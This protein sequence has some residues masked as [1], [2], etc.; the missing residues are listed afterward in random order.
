MISILSWNIQQGGGSRITAIGKALDEMAAHIVVLSEFR[1]NATGSKLRQRCMQMGYRHQF[2]SQA[3]ANANSV[4]VLSKLPANSTLFPK[5]DPVY[6]HNVIRAEFDAFS[7]YGLYMPH[8]KEHKL[9]DFLSSRLEQD[10]LPAI[11][12]GDFNSGINYVDQ[13]GNSFWYE[14]D[15]KSLLKNGFADAFRLKQGEVSEFSWYSHQGN[16]FR[17]DHTLIHED[18]KPVVSDCYYV[19]KYR[20]DKVSDHSPM[21][22]ELGGG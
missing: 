14:D 12:C 17:Y 20:E 5:A 9:F 22:I 16:G 8:K 11:Y 7:I 1:N 2:V 15:F 18:L 10:S 21:V 13:K 4:I 6:H 19:H 3:P